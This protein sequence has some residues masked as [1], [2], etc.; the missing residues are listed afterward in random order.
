MVIK[1]LIEQLERKYSPTMMKGVTAT[2]QFNIQGENEEG[3]YAIIEEGE[4]IFGEGQAKNPDTTISMSLE[5]LQKILSHELNVTTAF[6]TKKIK[7]K[8]SMS[9]AMKLQGLLS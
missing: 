7:I 9:K 6:L 2:Y 8:G 3:L 4:A 1:E 5:N